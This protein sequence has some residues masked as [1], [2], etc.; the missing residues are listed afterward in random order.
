MKEF[1]LK[2]I[3]KTWDVPLPACD[4]GVPS[5]DGH[6]PHGGAGPRQGDHHQ[7]A[8]LGAAAEIPAEEKTKDGNE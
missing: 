3:A 1:F 8:L 7:R 4:D 5:E 2:N 6:H